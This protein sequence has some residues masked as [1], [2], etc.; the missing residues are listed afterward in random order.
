MGSRPSCTFR[1]R[2][3]DR[4]CGRSA[5]SRRVADW[6]RTP[7]PALWPNLLRYRVRPGIHTKRTRS[8]ERAQEPRWR[9]QTTSVRVAFIPFPRVLASRPVPARRVGAIPPAQLVDPVDVAAPEHFTALERLPGGPNDARFR[10]GATEL[11]LIPSGR[12]LRIYGHG[13]SCGGTRRQPG[14]RRCRDRGC[15]RKSRHDTVHTG[16]SVFA[17][18]GISVAGGVDT[19]GTGVSVAV[20][21][22]CAA[23]C[24]SAV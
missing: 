22:A 1:P 5:H 20:G 4:C 3:V 9:R 16:V 13:A 21:A 23:D 7:S 15:R 17:G 2:R 14:Y 10:R 6:R 24:T 8:R 18:A 11:G 12:Q 19:A